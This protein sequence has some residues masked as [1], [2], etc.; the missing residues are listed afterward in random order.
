MGLKKATTTKDQKYL[1]TEN[2]QKNSPHCVIFYG[3][4]TEVIIL[5]Q[6]VSFNNNEPITFEEKEKEKMD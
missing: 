2:K 6:K 5:L 1:K 3:Y 4:T